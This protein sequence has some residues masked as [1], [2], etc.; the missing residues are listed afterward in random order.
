M[1]AGRAMSED[2]LVSEREYVDVRYEATDGV[3][4]ITIDRAE[5][6]NAFR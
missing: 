5:R 6:M 1:S 4:V 3:A 2:G